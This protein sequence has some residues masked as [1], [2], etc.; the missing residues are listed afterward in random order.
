MTTSF[1]KITATSNFGSGE[2][3]FTPEDFSKLSAT[4]LSVM[5]IAQTATLTPDYLAVPTIDNIPGLA[6]V[7]KYIPSDALVAITPSAIA[8]LPPASFSSLTLDKVHFLTTNQLSSLSLQQLNA[9]SPNQ[10]SKLNSNQMEAFNARKE[11]VLI[12]SATDTSTDIATMLSRSALLDNIGTVGKGDS[13]YL[14]DTINN[15]LAF[16]PSLTEVIANYASEKWLAV[17][18]GADKYD[19]NLTTLQSIKLKSTN[20]SS[21]PL[22]NQYA[23]KAE[24]INADK[25]SLPLANAYADKAEI[26]NTDKAEV[27]NYNFISFDKKIT[28][29]SVSSKKYSG[30]DTTNS[31]YKFTYKNIGDI[32]NADDINATQ[33]ETKSEKKTLKNSLWTNNETDVYGLDYISENYKVNISK[34]KIEKST[35][36]DD[37]VDSSNYTSSSNEKMTISKYSFASLDNVFSIAFTGTSTK[38]YKEDTANEKVSLN[39]VTLNTA[40]YNLTTAKVT[41]NSILDENGELHSITNATDRNVSID[42][43]QEDIEKYV[44]PNLMSGDNIITIVNKKGAHIYAG[45]GKDTISGGEGKD[46]ISG[47]AGSDKLTGGKGADTFKFALSDFINKIANDYSVF[48]KSVDTITDFN[49]NNGDVL[50][51]GNMGQLRFY[52]TFKEA[53]TEYA[54]LFYFNGKIYYNI[55]TTGE[56]YIPTVIITLTGTIENHIPIIIED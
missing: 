4:E 27:S 33:S 9:F 6:N 2:G 22:A 52:D 25:P 36:S 11:A 53:N 21:L 10:V 30:S 29:N 14:D 51:F 35:F 1:K 41:Y 54:Q 18:K 28:L 44:V 47:G 3:E 43:M 40:D 12:N 38:D 32:G 42:K 20:K 17:V 23:D 45:A 56:K 15:Y 16:D 31:T 26:I 49:W 46:T 48:N 7:L 55:D 8:G 34:R 37:S 50:D 39:K 5:S 13:V 19:P 24:I